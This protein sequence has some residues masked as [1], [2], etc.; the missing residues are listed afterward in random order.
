M[1]DFSWL[2]GLLEGEGSFLKSRNY[3]PYHTDIRIYLG[4]T[5]KDTVERA[6]AIM[7]G[8][9]WRAGK[10]KEPRYRQVWR[11][12]LTGQRAGELMLR[13]LP[14]MSARRRDQIK[15]AL[16]T[17]RPSLGSRARKPALELEQQIRC[18]LA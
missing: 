1:D 7:E 15:E 14:H 6:A 11:A 16:I 3:V 17:Y 12:A 13:L 9:V 10:P 5:D 8:T 18:A 4:M 2:V